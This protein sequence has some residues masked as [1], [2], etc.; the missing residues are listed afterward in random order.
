MIEDIERLWQAWAQ[1]DIWRLPHGHSTW[2]FC[3][4]YTDE[5][6][7]WLAP[8]LEASRKNNA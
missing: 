6:L 7:H 4:S 3:P 1:P 2:M 5:I 8:R